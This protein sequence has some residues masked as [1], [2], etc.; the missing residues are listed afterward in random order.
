MTSVCRVLDALTPLPETGRRPH[1]HPGTGY[2][3]VLVGA[4]CFIVNAGVSRVVMDAGVAADRLAAMRSTGTAL[5]L[6]LIVLL[7]GRLHTLRL[8][9]R[10]LPVVLLYGIVGVALLQVTYFIAIDRLPVGIALLLEYLAP[11]LIALWA[12]GVQRQPVRRRLWPALGLSLVGL[13]MVAQVWDGGSLDAL[14]VAMG[15]L[16]AVCFATYFLAGEHLVGQRDPLSTVFWGFAVATVFWAVVRPWWTFDPSVL[17]GS[18]TVFG[19][20]AAPVWALVVWVVLLGTL[21]P[22]GVETVA[23]QHLPATVVGTL[24]MVEPV[25]AAAL[26]WLWFGESLAPVQIVGGL[27]V[28]GAI[29]LAQTARVGHKG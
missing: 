9:R 24:A 25:G 2:A 11:V 19:D 6:L 23:L 20:V 13:A 16:A 3:L 5:V 26:A 4:S 14:G 29:L 28:I 27:V 10:E 17:G 8:S 22:F 21:V 1:A 18:T 12:F 15:L 7:S